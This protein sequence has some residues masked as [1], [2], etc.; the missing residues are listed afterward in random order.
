MGDHPW[1]GLRFDRL[2]QILQLA[3]SRLEQGTAFATN[4]PPEIRWS[5][6]SLRPFCDGLVS[7]IGVH[8]L[9]IAL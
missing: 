6:R 5:Y 8:H 3:L 1:S 7:S 4:Q 9:D 2:D